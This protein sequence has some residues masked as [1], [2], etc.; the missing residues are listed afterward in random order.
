[1]SRYLVMMQ[2]RR[3]FLGWDQ[4]LLPMAADW[5][6]ETARDQAR[7]R[8]EHGLRLDRMLVVTPA[9][10]AGR[11]LI[12]LLAQRVAGP[13]TPPKTVTPGQLPEELYE[14]VRPS[15]DEP[16]G[17]LARLAVLQQADADTL[18]RLLGPQAAPGASGR[19][20]VDPALLNLAEDLTAVAAT[21]GAEGLTVDD[22]V[23]RVADMDGFLEAERWA[24]IATL[25]RDYEC[26][27]AG[28]GLTDLHAARLDA[29]RDAAIACDRTIVLVGTNDLPRVVRQMLGA[30]AQG[31]TDDDGSP[32]PVTALIPAPAGEAESFD[33]LGC[34][35]VEA[36]ARRPTPLRD[37]ALRVVDRPLDQAQ[38]VLWSLGRIEP[39]QDGITVRCDHRPD[40]ITVG[41]GDERLGPLVERTLDMAGVPARLAIGRA[42]PASRPMTLLTAM[43]RF[44]TTQRMAAFAALVRHPDIAQYLN[45]T[46]DNEAGEQGRTLW[47]SLL[48]RYAN[49]HLHGRLAGKWLGD[50]GTQAALKATY[51]AVTALLPPDAGQA[52][53]LTSWAEP[54]AAM[55]AQVYGDRQLDRRDKRDASLIDALAATAR[56]LGELRQMPEPLTPEVDFASALRLVLTIARGRA[57]APGGGDA[58][59]E[60]LGWL[61]LGLDDAPRL[62]VTGFNEGCVPQSGGADAFLPDGMRRNLGITDDQRRYARDMFLLHVIVNSRPDAVFIAGRF[63]ARGEPLKP[64]RLALA[65]QGRELARRVADFYAAPVL[66]E[67]DATA[68]EPRPRAAPLPAG[69]DNNLLPTCPPP[70]AKPIRQLA[71]T[72]F[73]AYLACPY[74]FYLKYVLGLEAVDDAAAEMDALAFG[75]LG[76]DV[77]AWFGAGP[78]AHS[79]NAAAIAAALSGELNRQARK[80]FGPQAPPAALLQ[81]EQ[82]RERLAAFAAWQADQTRQGWRIDP[83][84]IEKRVEARLDVDGQPFTLVG[85]IDRV[86]LHPDKGCRV[87][88]YKFGDSGDKPEKTH[89]RGPVNDK[90]WIDL[91]LP[92]Y[93]HLAAAIGLDAAKV[94]LGYVVLPKKLADVRDQ[95]ADWSHD[96][97]AAADEEACRVIRAVRD[98]VFWP[99]GEPL[100]ALHD[101]GLGG[102]CFDQYPRRAEAIAQAEAKAKGEAR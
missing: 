100:D 35:R 14:S 23:R 52:R 88:D 87:L 80:H 16:A 64:S 56:L 28:S 89:R 65:L 62:T 101:D 92:L 102:L 73:R 29:L 36:W 7:D 1:M 51:D 72:A 76:H 11:R 31:G 57:L 8:G 5:L 10:R 49:D 22:V 4:P 39:A 86:D 66:S 50:E 93:R 54:M 68:H 3:V 42:L 78:L 70:L 95:L 67:Q 46:S 59:V 30:L 20:V 38:E 79:E 26:L 77:L 18:E 13:W 96:D 58:A 17:L 12:E 48:D 69:R 53:S 6:H 97:L 25:Q 41:L 84:L 55:L 98:G 43:A 82:M 71:V 81:I 37:A 9:A 83:A 90:Q 19:D 34:I 63:D 33:E 15:A 24:A 45:A 85:R 2:S 32:G 91:Q 21:L 44:T 47:I 60:L 27:L 61:E 40:A 99:P 94:Q 74:R 75:S